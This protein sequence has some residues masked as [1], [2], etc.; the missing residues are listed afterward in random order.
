MCGLRRGQK[1]PCDYHSDPE[2]PK[3]LVHYFWKYYTYEIGQGKCLTKPPQTFSFHVL[4]GVERKS[5]MKTVSLC[6]MLS[7]SKRI[8]DVIRFK[9]KCA[10]STF[11]FYVELGIQG[12]VLFT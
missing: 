11:L 2:P 5:A 1:I 9:T 12:E 3:I 7:I 6:H 8:E 4:E 10:F